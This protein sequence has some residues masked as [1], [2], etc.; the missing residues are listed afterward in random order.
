VQNVKMGGRWHHNAEK[1][2]DTLIGDKALARWEAQKVK[3][4]KAKLHRGD[5]VKTAAKR[6]GTEKRKGYGSGVSISKRL[7]D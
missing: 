4:Q 5:A 6:L 3:G 2:G 7:L 1:C